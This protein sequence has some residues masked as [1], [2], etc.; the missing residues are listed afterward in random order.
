MFFGAHGCGSQELAEDMAR[1]WLSKTDVPFDGDL[2]RH[3]DCLLIEPT[4]SS[5]NIILEAIREGEGNRERYGTPVI[6]FLRTRPL[7]GAKKVVFIFECDRLVSRAANALLKTLEELPEYARIILLTSNPSRVLPTIRSRVL[8]IGCEAEVD[9]EGASDPEIVFGDTY[10]RRKEIRAAMEAYALLLHLFESLPQSQ[11]FT[12]LKKSE[13]MLTIAAQIA[14]QRGIKERAA[15]ADV[16][17]C[18]GNYIIKKWPEKLDFAEEIAE[19]HRYI[20]G[21]ANASLVF[22][23]LL[24]RLLA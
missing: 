6:E 16:L 14:E 9:N 13:E 20:L 19:A 24:T 17:E 15:R 8:N 18:L 11:Q 23:A 4:G 5:A 21:N 10:G 12:A 2:W 22:D 1:H 7:M 3:V